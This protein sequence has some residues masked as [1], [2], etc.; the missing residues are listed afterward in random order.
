MSASHGY[1]ILRAVVRHVLERALWTGC[2]EAKIG[3]K[4]ERVVKRMYLKNIASSMVVPKSTARTASGG[5]GPLW[6]DDG[7]AELEKWIKTE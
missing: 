6:V 5:E 1:I 4:K 7:R 3:E 2:E